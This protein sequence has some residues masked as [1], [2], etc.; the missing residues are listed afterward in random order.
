MAKSLDDVLGEGNPLLLFDFVTQQAVNGNAT[1]E[2]K[3]DI[4]KLRK[5]VE[6]E[7]R[8]LEQYRMV[9]A[10][11]LFLKDRLSGRQEYLQQT[12]HKIEEMHFFS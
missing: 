6:N 3:E 8:K 12:L 7:G 4:A 9:Q 2:L 10:Y 1:P 11:M 5:E